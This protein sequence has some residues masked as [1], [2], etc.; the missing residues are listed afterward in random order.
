MWELSGVALLYNTGL[1]KLS[2]AAGTSGEVD[3]DLIFAVI[4]FIS[5][6]VGVIVVKLNAEDKINKGD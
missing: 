4:G 5:P 1:V 6:I 2:G 3:F